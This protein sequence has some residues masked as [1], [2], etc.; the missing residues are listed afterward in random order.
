M[1]KFF[2]AASFAVFMFAM[3]FPRLG[4]KTNYSNANTMICMLLLAIL[5]ALWEISERIK[6]AS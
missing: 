3:W 1:S 2:R 6:D 5:F 4:V